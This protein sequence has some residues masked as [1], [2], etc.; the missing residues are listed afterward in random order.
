M[1]KKILSN[2]VL[3]SL[4][5][6]KDKLCTTP[7]KTPFHLETYNSPNAPKSQNTLEKS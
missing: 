5:A 2:A 6:E 1:T 3:D 4:K 7:L